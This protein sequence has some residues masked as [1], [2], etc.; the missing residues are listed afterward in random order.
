MATYSTTRHVYRRATN[1]V[2]VNSHFPPPPHPYPKD[3]RSII[4]ELSINQSIRGESHLY[5]EIR[6]IFYDSHLVCPQ[7]PFTTIHQ[8]HDRHKNHIFTSFPLY[9]SEISSDDINHSFPGEF[10]VAR[11]SRPSQLQPIQFIIAPTPQSQRYTILKRFAESDHAFKP[12]TLDSLATYEEELGR[13]KA[14]A[15]IQRIA[16]RGLSN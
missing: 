6:V 10:C 8:V 12:V 16:D 7:V 1:H 2:G 15:Y 11:S 4:N 13:E 9:N 5:T 3:L 14:S